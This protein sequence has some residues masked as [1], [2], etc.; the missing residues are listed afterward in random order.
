MATK[1]VSTEPVNEIIET[2]AGKEK[3]NA[4]RSQMIA[5][6]KIHC[7]LICISKQWNE[8]C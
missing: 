3:P 7:K 5:L 6:K 8:C 1:K 4:K 2:E